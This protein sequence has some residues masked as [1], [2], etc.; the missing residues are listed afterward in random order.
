MVGPLRSFDGL[1]STGPNLV[2]L[3]PPQVQ[4]HRLISEEL[5][6]FDRQHL[7]LPP[8]EVLLERDDLWS[9]D[10]AFN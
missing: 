10:T 6:P 5:S 7:R 2:K 8:L 4:F 9:H 1:E 3:A